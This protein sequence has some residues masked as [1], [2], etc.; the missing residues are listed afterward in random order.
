MIAAFLIY[1]FFA[2]SSFAL[3]SF[4]ATCSKGVEPLLKLE[5]MQLRDAE[6]IKP[7]SSGVFFKGTD[8]T[9]FDALLHLRTALRLMESLDLEKGEDESPQVESPQELYDTCIDMPWEKY[10]DNT[11]A[12]TS[13]FAVSMTLGQGVK[14]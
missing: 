5:V 9:G 8:K 13:T 2:T 3:R 6:A 4:Y 11:V 1:I 10:I 14:K 12:Q 7:A